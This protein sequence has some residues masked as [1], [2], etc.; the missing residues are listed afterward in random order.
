MDAV[1]GKRRSSTALGVETTKWDVRG[2]GF[3]R[4]EGLGWV[5]YKEVIR[6]LRAKAT[7]LLSQAFNE[8][9]PTLL[10]HIYDSATKCWFCSRLT[11]PFGSKLAQTV[12]RWMPQRS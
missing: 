8:M 1:G 2:G 5:S 6:E 10:V 11:L 7:K 4:L 3:V 9:R 12:S